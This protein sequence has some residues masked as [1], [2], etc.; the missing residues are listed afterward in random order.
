M[1]YG[2]LECG[3]VML[4]DCML[5]IGNRRFCNRR[6][7]LFVL[8]PVFSWEY[9]ATGKCCTNLIA[10]WKPAQYYG[11]KQTPSYK[12]KNLWTFNR[13]DGTYCHWT[14]GFS[15]WGCLG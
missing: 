11:Q 1:S 9:E 5:M 7:A 13:V 2:V 8:G 6:G 10:W 14:K 15:V 4:Q 12:D 3:I